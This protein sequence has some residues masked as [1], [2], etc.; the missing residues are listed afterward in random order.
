VKRDNRPAQ[1]L[2]IG[3]S[4]SWPE[5]KVWGPK[6]AFREVERLHGNLQQHLM[7]AFARL[8]PPSPGQSAA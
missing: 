8:A 6:I 1:V 7:A 5:R 2:D 3:F 4:S